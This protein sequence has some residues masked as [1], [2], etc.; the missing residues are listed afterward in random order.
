MAKLIIKNRYG[1]APNELLNSK[2]I[3]LKAKGMFTY[4]QSKPDGWQFSVERI[5]T[6]M[7]ESVDT[8]RK[9]LQ[10]LEDFGYLERELKK[11]IDNGK[12]AGYDYILYSQ[13]VGKTH[14]RENHRMENPSTE[15]SQDISNKD[16]SKK[17]ISNKENIIITNS[18][19]DTSS[20][21]Q[22]T[23]FSKNPPSSKQEPWTK[24]LLQWLE[25]KQGAKFANYGKQL[26]ALGNLKKAGY[27]P[28]QIKDCYEK[29]MKDKFWKER[30]PDFMNIANN[31]TKYIK[32][33]D[34]EK[35]IEEQLRKKI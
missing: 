16:N 24:E 21:K 11:R 23:S 27:N 22:N 1:I 32:K 34:K 20:S 8:V 2:E 13:P 17:D 6:Q 7:K 3:S 10:E 29:M 26:K 15:K 28:E 30:L 9:T 14:H 5:A 31:I 25:E 33:V 35:F 18:E 19:L 4:L 12:F